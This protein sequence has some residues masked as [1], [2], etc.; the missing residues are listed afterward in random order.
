MRDHTQETQES[1]AIKCVSEKFS[2]LELSGGQNAFGNDITE[3][4]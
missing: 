2:L 4:Y 3:E 1:F